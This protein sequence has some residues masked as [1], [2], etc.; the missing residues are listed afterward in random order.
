MA[1]GRCRSSSGSAS[2]CRWSR[3]RPAGIPPT[4][5]RRTAAAGLRW[6]WNV[7]PSAALDFEGGWARLLYA[8]RGADG[9]LV[10]EIPDVDYQTVRAAIRGS[11]RLGPARAWV[12]VENRIVL[13]GGVVQDRFRNAKAQGL[14]ARLGGEVPVAGGRVLLRLDGAFERYGW[15]FEPMDTDMFRATGATD[16][17]WGLTGSIGAAY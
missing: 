6:R 9:G 15:T 7:N 1:S 10:E 3:P 11:I 4:P 2:G 13:S 12:G 8:F 17:V 14:G 5:T 16:L